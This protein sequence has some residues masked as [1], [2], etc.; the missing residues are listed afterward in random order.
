MTLNYKNETLN[1]RCIIVKKATVV[2][3]GNNNKVLSFVSRWSHPRCRL[4]RFDCLLLDFIRR[5]GCIVSTSK[6]FRRNKL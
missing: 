6:L 5:Q 3:R 1:K 2:H 4:R